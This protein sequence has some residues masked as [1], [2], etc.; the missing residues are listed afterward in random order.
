[1]DYYVAVANQGFKEKTI[2]NQ[3]SNFV[4]YA[5]YLTDKKDL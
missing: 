1:M 2:L 3:L 4:S 5:I